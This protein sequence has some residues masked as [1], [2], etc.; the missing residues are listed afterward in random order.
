MSDVAPETQHQ[1]EQFSPANP[2]TA[3]AAEFGPMTAKGLHHPIVGQR[4]KGSTGMLVRRRRDL[5]AIYRKRRLDPVF[6]EEI[7]IAVAGANSSRQCS[8]A[9]REWAKAEGISAAD[10]AALEG[11]DTE[12][13]DE[14]TWAAV[15]WAQAHARSDLTEAPPGVGAN[16][17]RLFSPQE[18]ADIELAV[19]TMYW[20]NEVSN[21]V[22]AFLSRA[23]RNRVPGSTALTELEALLLYGVAVPALTILFGAKQRRSPVKI[24]RG[25]NPFFREF[26]ARGPDTISGAGPNYRG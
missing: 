24:L 21:G 10:L 6:R 17:R 5:W 19:R 13:L 25:M 16:F 9:H 18:Q 3:G 2:A 12:S 14:R 4:K 26:E 20:L 15:A 11:L 8:F 22:D 1:G 23:R 7:M